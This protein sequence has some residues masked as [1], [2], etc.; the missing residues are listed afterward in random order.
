MER[1]GVTYLV[2]YSAH[3]I[4][5]LAQG[6]NRFSDCFVHLIIFG[7]RLL[8]TKMNKLVLSPWMFKIM[9]TTALLYHSAKQ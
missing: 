7:M 9:N 5:S 2:L 8:S 6:E 3:V 4:L 1:R